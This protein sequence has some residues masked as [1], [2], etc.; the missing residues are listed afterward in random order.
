MTMSTPD[1]PH[2]EEVVATLRGW[3]RPGTPIQLHPGDLG[4]FWRHGGEATAA[5]VR[6]WSRDGQLLGIGLLDGPDLL[7]LAIAPEA[8]HD[9]ALADQI[10]ADV[11]DPQRGVLP[12]GAAS[13]EAPPGAL[14]HDVL[15]EHGWAIDE[16]WS[17]LLRD[18]SEPVGDPGVRVEVIDPERA[19]VWAAVHCAAFGGGP[20]DVA[21]VE[22]RWHA[23]ARGVPFADARSLVAY[24]EEDDAV[25]AATVW[26]A[27]PGQYG[28]LEPL[29]AHPDHRG[30][31][32]GRAMAVAAA[33]ALQDLGSAAALV[34]TESANVA[35]VA[36]YQSAGFRLLGQRW[37]RRRGA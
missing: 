8:H 29:G 4:W 16:P 9:R 6:R 15:G 11:T 34:C 7:R 28:V 33:A 21:A 10:A 36:A 13:V 5:A 1:V 3:Q 22:G 24:D 2:L 12:E 17:M 32:H 23:K 35:A 14:V 30:R 19:G 37:D 25:A 26:S 31:G 20:E 27:G 18:L